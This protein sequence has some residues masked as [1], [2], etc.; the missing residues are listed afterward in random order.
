MRIQQSLLTSSKA[1]EAAAKRLDKSR[2]RQSSSSESPYLKIA[3]VGGR[4]LDESINIRR[5]VD[6]FQPIS[7]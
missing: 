6:I 7:T 2:K 3:A 1:N 5:R 4:R